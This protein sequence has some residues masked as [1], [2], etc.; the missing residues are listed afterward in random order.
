MN[1]ESLLSGPRHQMRCVLLATPVLGRGALISAVDDVLLPGRSG[2]QEARK[3]LDAHPAK[4]EPVGVP[5][6]KHSCIAPDPAVAVVPAGELKQLHFLRGRVKELPLQLLCQA[7]AASAVPAVFAL[8]APGCVMKKGKQ[9]DDV[10]TGARQRGEQEP[11]SP[12][13]RPVR[14]A[15]VPAPIERELLALRT[16]ESERL[17][18]VAQRIAKSSAEWTKLEATTHQHLTAANERELLAKNNQQ[19]AAID[20]SAVHL[21]EIGC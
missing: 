20:P 6:G 2:A 14:Y 1:I 4:V 16:T 12:H 13:T 9:F 10:R 15:V 17:E 21:L 18:S 5:A 7:S 11:I 3:R 19:G 8:V